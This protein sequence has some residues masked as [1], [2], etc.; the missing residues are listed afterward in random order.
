MDEFKIDK[1]V[2][3]PSIS[4][5]IS[6]YDSNKLFIKDFKY[7]EDKSCFFPFLLIDPKDTRIFSDL[8]Y[9]SAEIFGL[10]FHPS[11]CRVVADDRSLWKYY[12]FADEK[13]LPV[14]IHCGRNWISNISFIIDAA[15]IFPHV[16]F[17][18]AHLGGNASDLIEAALSLLSK[19]KVENLFLDTSNGKSPW[20]IEEAVKTIDSERLIFGSDEPFADTRIGKMCVYLAKLSDK[21]KENI[22]SL[23]ILRLLEKK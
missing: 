22:F 12:E 23:N 16:S 14:L 1:A 17:I 5:I 18:A 4:S 20:L 15:K 2:I 6:I 3:M 8:S 9:Y 7:L 21:D 19:S 13:K 10:K 11:I